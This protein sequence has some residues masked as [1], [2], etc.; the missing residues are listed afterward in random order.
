MDVTIGRIQSKYDD[1]FTEVFCMATSTAHSHTAPARGELRKSLS[2]IRK[3]L[4]FWR[5]MRQFKRGLVSDP[6]HFDPR[7]L[8]D[9][10]FGWGNSWSAQLEYLIASLE[11]VRNADGPV[12]ECGS[13]LSTVLIGA[14]AQSHGKSVLSLEHE[15]QFAARV[16][17][18]LEKYDIRSVNL[19]V[20]PLKSYG[21][22]D[23]YQVPRLDSIT[24]KFSVVIC[25]G[26]PG[27]TRGGR[28][29]LVPVMLEKLK[30]DCTILLDD[31]ARAEEQEIAARWAPMLSTSAEIL[32]KEKPFIRLKAGSAGVNGLPRPA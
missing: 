15:P 14:V 28:Y 27:A 4:T 18:H 30:P 13:G 10:V 7:V 1:G 6:G 23:W 3:R 5:A 17:D 16:R 21:D 12:L 9:L 26:P 31:G 20:A 29:G 11:H 19:F 22:F 2:K 8:S 24:E 32:G 25:D